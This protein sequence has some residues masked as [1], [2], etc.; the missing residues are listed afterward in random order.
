MG[1][2]TRHLYKE[3]E[4]AAA[5]MFCVL[6]GRIEEAAFWAAELLVSGLSDEFVSGLKTVWAYGFGVKALGWL[7][8]FE[9]VTSAEALDAGECLKLVVGL[10]LLG[11]RGCRDN[12]GLRLDSQA[13]LDDLIAAI[14]EA[15]GPDHESR[16]QE[17]PPLPANI[18]KKIEEWNEAL[19]RRARRAYSIPVDCLYWVTA[20]G[21]TGFTVYDTTE[22]EI[23][24]RL[25]KPA[26]GIWNSGFWD[27]AVEEYGGWQAIRDVA[28]Q[29]EAFYATYFPD[30]RPD[31]W[32]KKERAKSHGSGVLQRG[33][34]ATREEWLRRWFGA[35]APSEAKKTNAT[36]K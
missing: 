31:E 14:Q 10:A 13:P 18:R 19:D 33:Q 35:I 1:G 8:W 29:R 21:S 4:V 2:L 36:K 32:S 30:D 23:M 7:E 25:E 6:R 11:A 12:T 3:D 27:E 24:G 20:R 28:E 17:I 26:G 16:E 34:V 5:M 9:E 22:K 15:A